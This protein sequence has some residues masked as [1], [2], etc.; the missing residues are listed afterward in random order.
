MLGEVAKQPSFRLE[1]L[2]LLHASSPGSTFELSSGFS[3][4]VGTAPAHARVTQQDCT[5]LR[6]QSSGQHIA[7]RCLQSFGCILRLC[8]PKFRQGSSCQEM[9]IAQRAYCILIRAAMVGRKPL[10]PLIYST[11]MP[12]CRSIHMASPHLARANPSIALIF[13]QKPHGSAACCRL[14]FQECR[15]SKASTINVLDT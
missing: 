12:G 3:P 9:L 1:G 15:D 11:R 4:I 5:L 13:D 7:T 8:Q 14:C 2:G 10:R 6:A